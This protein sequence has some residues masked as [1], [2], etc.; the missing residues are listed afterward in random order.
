MIFFNFPQKKALFRV[1]LYFVYM[2]G[3]YATRPYSVFAILKRC[4]IRHIIHSGWHGD[5]SAE[6][7]EIT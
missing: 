1:H 3:A 6:V 5:P 2:M 4:I 7:A